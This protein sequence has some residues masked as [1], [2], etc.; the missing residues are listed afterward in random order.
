MKQS[1]VAYVKNLSR[2]SSDG[3]ETIIGDKYRK[4]IGFYW[5]VNSFSDKI[6]DV[7]YHPSDNKTLHITLVIKKKSDLESILKSLK[8]K[9]SDDNIEISSKKDTISI[10][11]T[12]DEE[13]QP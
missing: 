9:V 13:S 11:L 8:D 3:L 12:Q 7:E 10:I 1:M 6:D 5:L 2:D 4:F